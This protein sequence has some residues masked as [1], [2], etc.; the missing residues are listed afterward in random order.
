MAPVYD[1]QVYLRAASESLTLRNLFRIEGIVAVAPGYAFFLRPFLLA[2]DRDAALR[3]VQAAQAA[4]GAATCLLMYRLGRRLHSRRAGLAAAALICFYGHFVFYASAHMSETLFV[5][6]YYGAL[7]LFLRA[8]RRPSARRLYLAG[9]AAGAAALV[10][11]AAASLAPAALA[12]SWSAAPS[13]RGR[14]RALGAVLAG[15]LTILGP[16]ALRNGIASGHFDLVAPAGALNLL[17]GNHPDA[18]G[19]YTPTTTIDGD[20]WTRAAYFRSKVVD[21]L[22]NDPWGRSS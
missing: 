9:I 3:A 21:F 18:T 8:A 15:G 4:L 6:L 7:L 17:G 5:F 10:R 11:P 19:S 14:A 12:A 1:M 2:L 13:A 20:H 22:T 16:R